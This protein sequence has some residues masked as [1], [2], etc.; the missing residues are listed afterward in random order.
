MGALLVYD[1]EEN[2]ALRRVSV[3]HHTV[4]VVSMD[5]EHNF[6]SSAETGKELRIYKHNL[7]GEK[8][9]SVVEG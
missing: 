4:D 8:V 1:V 2:Q 6:V 3:G 5:A 9:R 7:K